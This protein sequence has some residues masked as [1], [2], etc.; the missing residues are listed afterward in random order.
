MFG[1]EALIHSG[2][3]F[4][5]GA[6]GEGWSQVVEIICEL[7]E[8]KA[9]LR[10]ECG[11]VLF[12]A[13]QNLSVHANNHQR[14]KHVLDSLDLHGLSKTPEGVAIWLASQSTLQ[15]QLPP[16]TWEYNDPLCRTEKP[17][18]AKVMTEAFAAEINQEE[19]NAAIN[20]KR[21]WS[22][23]LHFAWDVVLSTL[24][25]EQQSETQQNLSSER[26]SLKEFW[27]EVVD[28]KFSSKV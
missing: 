13:V 2:I 28:S 17:I 25:S 8:Q 5:T 20:K 12:R 15:E 1:A 4:S 24:I 6:G 23:K 3:L 26:L 27:D 9:H 10:E 22:P 21:N 14:I 16:A 7:A 19:H 18:I 11:W